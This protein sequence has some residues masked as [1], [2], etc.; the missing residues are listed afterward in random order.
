MIIIRMPQDIGFDKFKYNN[1]FVNSENKILAIPYVYYIQV[2]N[3]YN[4]FVKEYPFY[5]E[6]KDNKNGEF[7]Q[8]NTQN[9][10]TFIDDS[11]GETVD[12]N[13]DKF[14]KQNNQLRFILKIK[15]LLP[16][17]TR[18]IKYMINS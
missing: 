12:F 3:S 5:F 4:N 13:V 11:M 6:L 2:K 1:S 14:D 8:Q 10:F 15:N 16:N 18:Y 9:D 7:N 17:E